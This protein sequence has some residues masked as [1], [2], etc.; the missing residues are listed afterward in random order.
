MLLYGTLGLCA[1]AAVCLV[2]RYDMYDREPWY[3]VVLAL[4]LGMGIMWLVG[5][6]EAWSYRLLA[7][8]MLSNAVAAAV[9]ATQEEAARLIVVIAIA[10]TLRR[11][12]NDPMDGIIY[13]SLVGL[14]MAVT[15]S[16][17]FLRHHET[18]G[19]LL[20]GTEVVRVCGHLAMGGITGFAVGM[21]RLKMK[22]WWWAL[23]VCLAVS[24]GIHFFWDWIAFEAGAT[25]RMS[26]TQSVSAAALLLFGMVFYGA[27]VVKA[28][29]WSR[30][31]FGAD[32]P[33][34]LWGWPFT[35]LH[36]SRS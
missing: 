2:Y 35:L 15:E 25:G 4:L 36:R 10:L 20:P 12:F 22:G 16:I 21:A 11:Q 19:A 28:S 17:V 29:A 3:M 13:G 6:V 33:Q 5:V 1:L 31:I 24:M 7:H 32:G 23:A 8:H 14:G 26:A 27:L 9:P 18:A 34:R 30:E